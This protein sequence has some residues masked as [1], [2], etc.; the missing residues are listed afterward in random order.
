MQ[1][2]YR[3]IFLKFKLVALHCTNGNQNSCPGLL[4]PATAK[5]LFCCC[6]LLG[7]GFAAG[8]EGRCCP[9]PGNQMERDHIVQ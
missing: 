9:C 3:K 7:A 6:G 4:L 1:H 5:L 2:H 8:A